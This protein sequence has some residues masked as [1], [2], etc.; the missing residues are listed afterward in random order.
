MLTKEMNQLRNS[1]V[2]KTIGI[3]KELTFPVEPVAES[4]C[5][6]FSC[7][8]LLWFE[9]VRIGCSGHIEGETI[10]LQVWHPVYGHITTSDFGTQVNLNPDSWL[11]LERISKYWAEIPAGLKVVFRYNKLASNTNTIKLYADLYMHSVKA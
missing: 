8:E 11:Q 1:F 3:Q 4:D 9:G 5:L 10:D 7:A 6:V 2:T